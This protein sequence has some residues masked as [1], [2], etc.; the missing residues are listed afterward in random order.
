MARSVTSIQ[1]EITAI[2]GL[3]STSASLNA[4]V[5]ADGVSRTIDRTGLESRLDR[6]Y[7]QLGRADGS[8]PMFARGRIRGL[9]T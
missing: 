3:L 7:Q 4:N 9:R 2:E 8:N 5:A 1:A 6:L